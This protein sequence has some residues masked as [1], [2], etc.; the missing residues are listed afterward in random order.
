MT[1]VVLVVFLQ[2]NYQMDTTVGDKSKRVDW[3]GTVVFVQSMVSVLIALSWAGTQYLWSS[4][5]IIVPLVL[6]FVGCVVFLF[7][8]GSKFC[9]EPTMP[10]HLFKSRM[11]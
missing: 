4:F 2:V 11:Q 10:L 9:V 7:Y 6:G 8:E 3:T 1:L 5:R